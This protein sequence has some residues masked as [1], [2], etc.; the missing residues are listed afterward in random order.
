MSHLLVALTA[1]GFGHAA[2]A[3]PVINALR[4]RLPSLQLTLRSNLP[5]AF[6]ATRFEGVFDVVPSLADSGMVMDG[7]LTVNVA[8]SMAAY[9]ELH[10]DWDRHVHAEA[11]ALERI[12]PDLVLANVSYLTLAGAAAAGIPAY[13]LSSL[14]WADIYS[15]YAKQSGT[16]NSTAGKIH[17]QILAAY[18]SAHA[19]LQTEPSM[20][21]L[22]L[23][24][25][26]A[27]GVVA[28]EGVNRREEINA[29]LQLA[30]GTRL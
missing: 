6:L 14:N 5:R 19:F 3:A 12:A 18:R 25:R 28:R 9:A 2:Q 30:A 27:I 11:Q 8:R 23:P 17:D 29:K 10:K 7:A 13:A 24:N 15:H 16:A 4:R 20:P 22:D 21:M 1:H 26:R